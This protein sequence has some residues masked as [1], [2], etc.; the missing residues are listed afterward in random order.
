[1]VGTEPGLHAVQ[2]VVANHKHNV[3][4]PMRVFYVYSH[5][6]SADETSQAAGKRTGQ[7]PGKG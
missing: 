4:R 3:L 7:E 6:L 1:M 5:S 2:V